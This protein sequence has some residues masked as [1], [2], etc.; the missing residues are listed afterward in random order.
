MLSHAVN[1]LLASRK[2]KTT[3][4]VNLFRQHSAE[5]LERQ[6]LSCVEALSFQ[7]PSIPVASGESRGA[8]ER[9]HG[10]ALAGI[11][12]FLAVKRCRGASVQL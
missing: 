10:R 4:H 3:M 8:R 5:Q 9:A 11:G 2:L 12:L 1:V 7:R 6:A